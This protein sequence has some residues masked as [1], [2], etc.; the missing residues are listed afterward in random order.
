MFFLYQHCLKIFEKPLDFQQHFCKVVIW[1]LNFS[2]QS[3]SIP[4]T[5]SN[6]LGFKVSIHN[7]RTLTVPFQGYDSIQQGLVASKFQYILFIDYFQSWLYF[8]VKHIKIIIIG[9]VTQKGPVSKI[10]YIT[11]NNKTYY[12]VLDP[13]QNLRYTNNNFNPHVKLAINLSS[14]AMFYLFNAW[15]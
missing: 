3:I 10:K 6:L 1:I 12:I 9:I 4:K 15:Q 11:E 5:V 14:L 8:S 7:F 2:F 13:K